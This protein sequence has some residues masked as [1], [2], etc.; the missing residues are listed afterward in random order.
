MGRHTVKLLGHALAKLQLAFFRATRREA[1]YN[2]VERLIA[3][4]RALLHR[5][6]RQD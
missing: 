4:A 1:N 3:E 6:K 2:S 5:K